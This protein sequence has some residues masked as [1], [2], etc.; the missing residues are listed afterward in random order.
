MET[1]EK[2]VADALTKLTSFQPLGNK[3]LIQMD[4][5]A[6]KSKGGL[7]IPST[8]HDN[9]NT[10]GL[11]IAVGPEVKEIKPGDKLIFGKYSYNELPAIGNDMFL[12]KESD[13][14]AIV[15]E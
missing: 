9:F 8:V 13:V 14:F 15:T 2:N 12:I 10:S 3:V 7:F 6:E 1:F 11:A 4:K 5:P